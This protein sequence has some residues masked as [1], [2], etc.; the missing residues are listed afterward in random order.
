MYAPAPPTALHLR[1][2]C[3]PGFEPPP[4][5]P[6][7]LD[8][9]ARASMHTGQAWVSRRTH[10]H[11]PVWSQLHHQRCCSALL[12]PHLLLLHLPASLG[13]PAPHWPSP[14]DPLARA[15]LHA[16][17]SGMGQ[18]AYA[19]PRL[20]VVTATAS[21]VLQRPA[22][23]HLLLHLPVGLCVA[24]LLTGPCLEGST[25]SCKHCRHVLHRAAVGNSHRCADGHDLH[26]PPPLIELRSSK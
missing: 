21:A 12:A 9:L 5:W 25:P 18:Q 1:H 19:P 3:G 14:L 15:C 23:L 6:S 16:H 8:P 26:L 24:Q 11:V 2:H 13:L 17:R 7:P 20:S 4:Q 10:H 22:G